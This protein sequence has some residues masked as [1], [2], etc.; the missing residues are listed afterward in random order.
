MGWG[1]VL[2]VASHPYANVPFVG[3]DTIGGV[4]AD[5]SDAR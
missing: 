2:I 5:P 1:H 3:E 4:E